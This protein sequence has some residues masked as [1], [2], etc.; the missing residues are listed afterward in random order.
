[1]KDFVAA[2]AEHI[3]TASAGTAAAQRLSDMT[4]EAVR[5]LSRAASSRAPG[6]WAVIALGGWGAGALQPKSDL[7]ILV[8]SEAKAEQLKPFVEALLY[9]LW[10]AGLKVGHQVRSPKQQ[11]AA[12]RDDVKTCT[13]ALTARALAG[14]IEWAEKAAAS[15]VASLAKR[16]AR[17]LK[18]LRERE[19]PGSPYLLEPDLKDGAGGRRDYDE[20]VWTGALLTGGV[21]RTP[22]EAVRA[23]MLTAEEHGALAAAADVVA[24]ARWELQRSGYGDHLS[25]DGASDLL[26][27]SATDVQ[28]ALGTSAAVLAAVRGRLD[29]SPP[30][31]VQLSCSEVFALLDH[32]LSGTLPLELAAQR[33]LLEDVFPGLRELMSCRRPG[34]GHELTVGAHCIKAAALVAE[35]GPQGIL[36]RSLEQSDR[37]TVQAAALAHDVAKRQAGPGHAERGASEAFGIAERLGLSESASRDVADLVRLHL[38]LPETALRKNLDD[39]NAVLSCAAKIGRAGL[40]AP[41]H[42]LCAVDSLATGPSTWTGWT[43]ALVG[44]LVSRLDAALSEDVDGAGLAERGE[45]VRERALSQIPVARDAERAF[46]EA[47][48]LRY[49]ASREPEQVARDAQLVSGLAPDGGALIAVS[50]GPAHGSHAVTVAAPDR[51]Q[52]LARLAGAMSLAGL[53][54]LAVDAYGGPGR[55]ALDSFVVTSAT[56][57]PVTTE[58]FTALERFVNAALRDRL[59]LATRLAERRRHYPPRASGPVKVETRPA[60]WDTIVEV[61]A[62]DRPGLLHD[63]A[64]AVAQAGLDVRWAKVQTIE[65]MARDTFHVVG[66]DGSRVDDP[67]VLGH[68]AMHIR[69]SL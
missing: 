6:R 38:L 52:L 42:V 17:S 61:T 47:A 39:E 23:G 41:L 29:G 44:T 10:D 57:R 64:L 20:I 3:A 59:E 46:V 15:W 60:G 1:M 45:S 62:P 25:L 12:M 7:D 35:Q 40:I 22:A 8:L 54:I 28:A 27:V 65:G 16:P 48:P 32:G 50:A 34:L 37:R 68:V 13:A 14:D 4:D 9:P 19:R 49:L 53:D 18:A 58:T 66:P 21:A 55:V 11:L 51:P 69:D 43:A 56:N 26:A 63:V 31:T 30:T 2:R 67:G 36:G 5:E 33:G 24:M